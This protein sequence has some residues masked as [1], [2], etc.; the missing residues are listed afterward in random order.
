MIAQKY[1]ALFNRL[2]ELSYNERASLLAQAK[3]E[4]AEELR[5]TYL[6][7][8]LPARA[9]HVFRK[10]WTDGHSEGLHEVE[11]QYVQ[12]ADLVLRVKGIRQ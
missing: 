7:Y 8:L 6:S 3:A 11:T 2:H 5:Q 9:I 10:A 12:L 4:L 1:E